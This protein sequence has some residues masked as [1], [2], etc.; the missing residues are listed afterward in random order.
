MAKKEWVKLIDDNGNYFLYSEE[1]GEVLQG[2]ELEKCTVTTIEDKKKQMYAIE[3]THYEKNDTEKFFWY[4]WSSKENSISDLTPSQLTTLMYLCTFMD[5]DNYLK[6]NYKTFF[7]REDFDRVLNLKQTEVYKFYNMLMSKN[8]L[9]QKTDVKTNKLKYKINPNIFY[10][11]NFDS[12]KVNPNNI[13]AVRIYHNIVKQLYKSKTSNKRLGYLFKLI[14]Y[15]HREINVLCNNPFEKD[16]GKIKCLTLSNICDILNYSTNHQ[17]NLFKELSKITFS[18]KE[19]D[20]VWKENV[21][22]KLPMH[23]IGQSKSNSKQSK[24]KQIMFGINPLLFYAGTVKDRIDIS[25]QY[26]ITN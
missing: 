3:K 20:I 9:M 16:E 17:S 5:Y 12:K 15:V 2:E 18:R 22:K 14:P 10:R 21:F 6:L 1:T 19:W 26:C 4:L 25:K 23:D 11:G 13:S 7:K 24:S 8:I